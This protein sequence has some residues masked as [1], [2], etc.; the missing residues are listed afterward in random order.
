MRSARA[1]VYQAQEQ[2]HKQFEERE[3]AEST[4]ARTRADETVR[5][6]KTLLDADVEAA[7][8]G[9]AQQSEVLAG[10]IAES[11]LRRSAA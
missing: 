5:Q 7:R 6:A 11:L 8:A 4:A 10:Q 3:A 2:L 1:A 9:L